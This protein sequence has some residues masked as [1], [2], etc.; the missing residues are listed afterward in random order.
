MNNILTLFLN[1]DKEGLRKMVKE[2]EDK[3]RKL[4]IE[5]SQVVSHSK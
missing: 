4:W 3:I 2:K 1:N 5:L